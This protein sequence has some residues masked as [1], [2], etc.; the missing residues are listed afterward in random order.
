MFDQREIQTVKDLRVYLD[1][2][3]AKWDGHDER[4][5]GKFWDQNIRIPYFGRDNQFL[6]YGNPQITTGPTFDL[7]FEIPNRWLKE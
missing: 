4:Y 7:T 6:G 2:M 5:M 1:E 3:E